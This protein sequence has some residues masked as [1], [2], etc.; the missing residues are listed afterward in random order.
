MNNLLLPL[1]LGGKFR[2]FRR[3]GVDHLDG[4]VTLKEFEW[5]DSEDYFAR[6]HKT[7][8]WVDYQILNPLWRN[9]RMEKVRSL[10]NAGIS[11]GF[12]QDELEKCLS[13][14]S[15]MYWNMKG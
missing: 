14:G 4:D 2:L 7:L 13:T 10:V 9:E 12:C 15:L 8:P 6:I 11:L 3:E 5:N 1:P